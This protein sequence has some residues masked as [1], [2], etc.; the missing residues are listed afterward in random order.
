M[1]PAIAPRKIE[2]NGGNLNSA[3]PMTTTNGANIHGVT[4]NAFWIAAI[5]SVESKSPGW[6]RKKNTVSDI[7]SDTIEVS[8]VSRMC[9]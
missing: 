3:S 6:P 9:V 5:F 1:P 4:P 7:A 2:V 8:N